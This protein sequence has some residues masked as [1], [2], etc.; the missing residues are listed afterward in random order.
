MPSSSFLSFF[1]SCSSC[2]VC[3]FLQ[4]KTAEINCRQA[5]AHPAEMLPTLHLCSAAVM[6]LFLPVFCYSFCFQLQQA[7]VCSTL[8]QFCSPPLFCFVFIIFHV[9]WLG[10]D[11][12]D[13]DDD[14]KY[15]RRDYRMI[16]DDLFSEFSYPFILVDDLLH[17]SGVFKSPFSNI[18]IFWTGFPII[19][20]LLIIFA[21]LNIIPPPPSFGL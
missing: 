16:D 14:G 6:P 21:F 8:L 18:L 2:L 15:G 7:S 11:E 3:W 19:V 20:G 5:V 12:D 17:D 4:P 1:F 9:W 10:H 13:D